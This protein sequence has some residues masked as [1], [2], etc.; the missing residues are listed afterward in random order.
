MTAKVSRRSLFDAFRAPERS[1]PAQPA[2]APGFS[3]DAFY[4][5]RGAAA[6]PLP[7]ASL[8]P[9]LPAVTTTRVGLGEQRAPGRAAGHAVVIPEGGK[10]RV[11]AHTCLALTGSFC[12]TCSERCP[13]P[14]AIVVEAGR[15]R[16]DEQVC[17]GCGV[18]VGLCPAPING[19]DIVLP[20]REPSRGV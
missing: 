15:P 16:V 18:C 1:A 4:A 2:D 13:V 8:R 6:A 5:G 17:T 12:S 9:G 7:S 19:F 11:R 20:R 14:G 3:L 10:V